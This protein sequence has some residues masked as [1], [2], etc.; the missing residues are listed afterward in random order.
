[1]GTC[2]EL[3][4]KGI[5]YIEALCDAVMVFETNR[6]RLQVFSQCGQVC[7]GVWPLQNAP[8]KRKK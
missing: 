8:R 3:F 1:M 4:E 7:F 2:R 5:V 6:A